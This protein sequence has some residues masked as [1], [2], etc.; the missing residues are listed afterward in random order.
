M[1]I[2]AEQLREDFKNMFN[3]IVCT[4]TKRFMDVR[5]YLE[6]VLIHGKILFMKIVLL[7]HYW[8]IYQKYLIVCNMVH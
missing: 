1:S 7:E 8:L 5:I 3:D 4:Y 2:M 6:N